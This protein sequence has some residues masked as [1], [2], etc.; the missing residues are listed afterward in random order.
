MV[1]LLAAEKKR[2]IAE[3]G[4][5]TRQDFE[6][7]WASCWEAMRRE[8]SWPHATN[9][10][11]EWRRAQ[12]RTRREMRAAFIGEPT[13][14]S[15]AAGRVAEA[16]SGMCLQLEPEQ[17]GRALLAAMA[18]VEIDDVAAA[19]RASFAAGDFILPSSEGDRLVA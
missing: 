5:V 15:F 2:L 1:E 6:A 17:V 14:F 8:H 4:H 16:A 18:Y 11:R 7:A 13:P 10:R 9:Q 3:K 19:E 12:Q